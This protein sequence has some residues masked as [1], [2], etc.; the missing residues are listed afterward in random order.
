MNI[1]IELN[2]RIDAFQFNQVHLDYLQK[3][4]P[5]HTFKTVPDYK[6]LIEQLDEA[7]LLLCW[8]FNEDDYQKYHN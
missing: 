4:F 2:S 6:T 3:Q 5:D 8:R 1:L 7:E